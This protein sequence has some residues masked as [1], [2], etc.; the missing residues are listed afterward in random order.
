MES[1]KF[2]N[3]PVGFSDHTLGQVAATTA[4]GL[5]ATVF[6]K[7]FTMDKKDAGPDHFY[8]LEPAELKS[9]VSAIRDAHE[10]LGSGEKQM[11]PEEK[12]QGRREGLYLSRQMAKGETITQSDIVIKR[13]ANGL[14][15]RYAPIVVG[16]T[17]AIIRGGQ[18]RS[19]MAEKCIVCIKNPICASAQSFVPEV[20]CKAIA[21]RCLEAGITLLLPERYTNWCSDK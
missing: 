18:M 16:A 7:H 6:E 11:L 12:E 13:P 10:A 8:A 21:C 20:A 1:S 3:C 5:G 4:V 2:F 19:D 15:A 17:L 14:R 9:Y